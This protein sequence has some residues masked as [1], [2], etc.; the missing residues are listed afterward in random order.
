[1]PRLRTEILGL[2]LLTFAAVSQADAPAG[3][4]AL[5]EEAKAGA[6]FVHLGLEGIAYVDRLILSSDDGD[7]NQAWKNFAEA[8]VWRR[9]G[10]YSG[11][12]LAR[13]WQPVIS[14][15]P[16]QQRS[17]QLRFCQSIAADAYKRLPQATKDSVLDAAYQALD[18][19]I[20]AKT[21][22]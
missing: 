4:R 3:L 15:M 16:V 17:E 12:Q 21:A 10:N 19:A 2:V 14:E 13:R 1:M 22:K 20:K 5:D 8:E 6:C 18:V 11:K 9:S 7:K